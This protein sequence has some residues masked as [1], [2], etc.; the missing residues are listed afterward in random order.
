MEIQ[1][2]R[3]RKGKENIV[4]NKYRTIAKFIHAF[5]V[6]G[7]KKRDSGKEK[8]EVIM[9]ENFLKTDAKLEMMQEAQRLQSNLKI[10]K[11]KQ[12]T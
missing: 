9:V 3:E 8:F 4:S 6:L 1:R 5:L 2:E 10:K 12:E 7:G 11:N